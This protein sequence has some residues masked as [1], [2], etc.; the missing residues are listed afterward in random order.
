[1]ATL[2]GQPVRSIEDANRA[3]DI[4]LA[5]GAGNV[6]ITLGAQ[7]AFAKNAR[8]AAHV[9]AFHAGPVVE[10]TGAGDAFNGA[11]AVALSEG[12]H[13]IEAARLGCAAAGISVTRVGTALAMPRRAEVD[14]L[15]Q[16][17]R[18][19]YPTI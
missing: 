1:A 17:N 12:L 7:G 13:L 18:N 8:I 11:L 16:A 10:T 2:T 6:V 15:L 5:R 9:P 4:L 14:A 19:Q 3:A